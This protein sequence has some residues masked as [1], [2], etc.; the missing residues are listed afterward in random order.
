MN[1]GKLSRTHIVDDRFRAGRIL[2]ENSIDVITH[3]A[4]MYYFTNQKCLVNL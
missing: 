4:V 3:L 1:L 2:C